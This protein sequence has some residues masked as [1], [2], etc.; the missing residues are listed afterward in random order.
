M[1]KRRRGASAII[2]CAAGGAPRTFDRAP[3]ADPAV[4]V[5]NALL[6]VGLPALL[7]WQTY[8]HLREKE[9]P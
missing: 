9:L 3:P 5:F 7:W 1:R 4:H 2:A 8:V 6:W